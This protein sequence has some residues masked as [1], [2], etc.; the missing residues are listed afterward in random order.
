MSDIFTSGPEVWVVDGLR[1]PFAKSGGVL[2]DMKAVQLGVHV[3]RDLLYRMSLDPKTID[4]VVIGNTGSPEDAANIARIIALEAG[5]PQ[6]VPAYTVHRNCASAMESV[7]QGFMKIKAGLAETVVV[8]GTESMSN[9]PLI[10]S[11]QMTELFAGLMG[12]KTMPAKL[13][14]MSKFRPQFLKPII[15]IQEGL[16]DA[17]C[18]L[19][20]GQT[21]ELL[22]RESGITR[23]DQDRFALRS[24][25]RAIKATESGRFKK[26]ISPISVAP[27]YETF[28]SEDLGPRKGQSLEALGKLKPYFDRKNG[29]VTVGNACPITDGSCM[30][31]LMRADKAKA[32]GYKPLGKIRSF[33]FA[34]LEP[35]RMGLGPAYSS[36]K[37]LDAAGI[38]LREVGVVEVNEAFA[39][40][41]LAVQ[42]MFASKKF[43][44]EKL[45]RSEATGDI[46]DD[47]L[48][49]NGGAIA[50]GHPV[51]TTGARLVLTAL[52]ELHERNAQFGL[53]TLCIGG[54]QGGSVIVEKV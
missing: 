47:I 17:V 46:S 45:G 31:I 30:L 32:L 10:Y 49:I 3:L 4:D 34:G 21:A 27:R 44:Q 41:V 43:A 7:S 52:K 6:S 11:K 8:G 15:A 48:N 16:T 36:P 51:G 40:Q 54:G 18:G 39:A 22:A 53:A 5:I 50:L 38:T 19:N 20:M 33:A 14:V 35:E 29:T 42:K 2:K 37:A 23:D 9:M 25:E 26:E 24:H 1:S 13:Q 12:A 28:L